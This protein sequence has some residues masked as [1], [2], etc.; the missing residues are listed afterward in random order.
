MK[1]PHSINKALKDCLEYLFTIDLIVANGYKQYLA[2]LLNIP[3]Y[4]INLGQTDFRGSKIDY[5]ASSQLSLADEKLFKTLLQKPQF[6][7]LLDGRLDYEAYR[8]NAFFQA[9]INNDT[10]N[11]ILRPLQIRDDIII[12]NEEDFITAL[13]LKQKSY[14]VK[15]LEKLANS[16]NDDAFMKMDKIHQRLKML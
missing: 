4:H 16:F 10:N 7:N 15:E 12:Y 1:N 14:L 3:S 13:K 5:R 2:N 8:D 6:L 9:I 11:E